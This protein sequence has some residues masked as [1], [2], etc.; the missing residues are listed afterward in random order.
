MSFSFRNLFSQDESGDSLGSRAG[1]GASGNVRAQE[2]VVSEL[3]PFIPPAIVAQSGIPLEQ[4]LQIVLPADGG[5]DVRLSTIYQT[6]PALFAAEI[7]P[8]N[9]SV[10]S[11]PP[12]EA[13][14]ESSLPPGGNPFADASDE[15][16]EAGEREGSIGFAAP[17][18]VGEKSGERESGFG[19][20]QATSGANNPFGDGGVPEQGTPKEEKS[21]PF[22]SSLQDNAFG[23]KP[24]AP[25][26]NPFADA[27]SF[28]DIIKSTEPPTDAA[29]ADS[30]P[31]SF[32]PEAEQE[33]PVEKTSPPEMPESGNSFTSLF[34]RKADEENEKA[35]ADESS[36]IGNLFKEAT[37]EY[38]GP[39]KLEG[40][41]SAFAELNK[42]ASFEAFIP[43]GMEIDDE[44]ET[45][46]TPTTEFVPP[47][48]FSDEDPE[49]MPPAPESSVN[50]FSQTDKEE[51]FAPVNLF[52]HP[53]EPKA[54]ESG[55]T[56]PAF[57]EP[58]EKEEVS[59][60]G[61]TPDESSAPT[62]P[63]GFTPNYFP[64]TE[65]TPDADE[66][67]P[68]NVWP[69]EPIEEAP[70][71]EE[72]PP[73]LEPPPAAE[74]KPPAFEQA[75]AAE[76]KPPAFE[77]APAAE[78]K[79]PAFEQAPEAEEKPPALEQ[80]PAAEEKPPA[81]EQPPAAEEEPPAIEEPP[82]AEEKPPAF[83][84]PPA[85][86][87]K[88]PAIEEPPAVEEKPPAFEQPPAA[89][90]KP[91]AFEQAPEAEEKPPALEQPPAEEEEPP[92]IEQPPAAEEKP[93][94][95][96]QPP[97][98]EEK[99]PVSEQAPAVEEKPP[100]F[101][102]P[103]VT[104]E[105]P[106]AI[107]EPPAAEEKP[108]AVEQPT[109]AEFTPSHEPPSTNPTQQ[110]PSQASSENQ[111]TDPFSTM[112]A[113]AEGKTKPEAMEPVKEEASAA[114]QPEPEQ[115]S[116]HSAGNSPAQAVIKPSRTGQK[117][118]IVVHPPVTPE[119]RAEPET[120]EVPIK[121]Q[122]AASAPDLTHDSSIRDIALRAIFSTDENFTLRKVSQKVAA[123][124]GILACA[125]MTSDRVIEAYAD[126]SDAIGDKI[127]T[128][129]QHVR[130]LAGLDGVEG[131]SCFTIQMGQSIMSF[132][133][134][135][136]NLLGVKHKADAFKPGTRE[137]LILIARSLDSLE[138]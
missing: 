105:E 73:A 79:P 80:P 54:K 56:P 93:P 88:P 64:A 65:A 46:G 92:A 85:A 100:A 133:F 2:Y 110:R 138:N 127:Q 47:M 68:V 35:E 112:Q 102:Q 126:Q 97:A 40:D 83:E 12:R 106:P 132:F 11:L 4:K 129:A 111:P 136:E 117:Q 119:E 25:Q 95:I 60:F 14:S 134:G 115:D 6:C 50:L 5:F 66:K 34:S 3:L 22:S 23:G 62:E 89:E 135:D 55:E 29:P 49:P 74:E 32:P 78:E 118:G 72:Q 7:T 44:E 84:Q 59:L 131:T 30:G 103:P 121:R 81:L 90:E 1:S 18:A 107:E 41:G 39:Q 70:A 61:G 94:V 71:A 137:K 53:A 58:K 9:D 45:G 128:M 76:E 86:E 99:P 42:G 19:F 116:A 101:E 43:P 124:D 109:A 27:G 122:S 91:P 113:Q 69:P 96:E 37:G 123:M 15:A 51:S 17:V 36:P 114:S 33:K 63:V 21:A 120:K 125:V 10:I 87:E 13:G 104:E 16:I 77:Q 130:G 26:G 28:E 48:V 67:P 82:A 98:A 24:A 31:P 57:V 108:P 75:P 52:G 20:P 38:I 8:L